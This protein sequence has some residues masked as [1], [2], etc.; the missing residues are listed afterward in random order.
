MS[1]EQA[2]NA[3]AHGLLVGQRYATTW[4]L[5]LHAHAHLLAHFMLAGIYWR[6]P[7]FGLLEALMVSDQAKIIRPLGPLMG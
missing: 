4:A 5:F 6:E 3:R 2:T 7:N 1:S